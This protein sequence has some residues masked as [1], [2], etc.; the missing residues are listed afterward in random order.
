VLDVRL[1]EL[2]PALEGQLMFGGNVTLDQVRRWRCVFVCAML[3]VQLALW[4]TRSALEYMLLRTG[5]LQIR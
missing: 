2:L 5:G 1:D 4:L 3:I